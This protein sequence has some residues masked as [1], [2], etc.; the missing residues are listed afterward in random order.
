MKDPIPTR[1]RLRRFIS[2]RIT[3]VEKPSFLTELVAS[4]I[5]VFLAGWPIILLGS[6]MTHLPR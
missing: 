6:T 2:D 1:L 5:L 4:G 3:S